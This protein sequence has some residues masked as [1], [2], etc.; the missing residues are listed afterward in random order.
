MKEDDKKEVEKY[1]N[2][3]YD[4]IPAKLSTTMGMGSAITSTPQ[5]PQK[6]PTT[7]K[8]QEFSI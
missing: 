5:T 6:E 4:D 7:W 2:D 1:E 8:A 3:M